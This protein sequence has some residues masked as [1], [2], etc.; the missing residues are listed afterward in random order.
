MTGFCTVEAKAFRSHVGPGGCAARNRTESADA[1][2]LHRGFERGGAPG[3]RARAAGFTYIGVL[4]LVAMLGIAVTLVSE[5]WYTA[6]KREKE[7]ELLFV[8]NQFRRALAMYSA[9]GGG[10]PKRLEDLLRDPRLPGV[11]RYLR[12]IYRDPITGGTEWG[13]VKSG[14]DVIVGIHSLSAEVPLKQKEFS[15]ADKDFVG[16]RKYSEWVFSSAPAQATPGAP[17]PA[18]AGVP[19]PAIPGALTPADSGAAQG[20]PT[21]NRT[22]S[23]VR[24]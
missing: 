12:K 20:D 14:G 6:Q 21:L 9:N 4:L 2:R 10:N 1:L 22:Q 16:K 5:L 7:Q 11:R 23:R 13:L 18:N 17:T 3:R 24:R 15:L 8:G 19:T